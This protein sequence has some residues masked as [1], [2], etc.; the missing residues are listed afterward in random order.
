MNEPVQSGEN[1]WTRAFPTPPAADQNFKSPGGDMTHPGTA[2]KDAV[3]AV[4]EVPGLRL[5]TPPAPG[6]DP[7]PASHRE[8][9][10]HGYPAQPDAQR[11][12]ELHAH[13]TTVL[14]RSMTVIT[15]Q[16]AAMPERHRRPRQ[17][18][19]DSATSL[20]ASS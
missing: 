15:L 7:L 9:P 19:A 3:A 18:Y 1:R 2:D 13:W 10:V 17:D 20:M 6:L 16:L 5:F 4:Y 14:S 12:P 8:L 11:H